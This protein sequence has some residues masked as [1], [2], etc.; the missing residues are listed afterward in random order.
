[1]AT[2]AI[3]VL[4]KHGVQAQT[5]PTANRVDRRDAAI[6]S[7]AGYMRRLAGTG[8]AFTVV[9]TAQEWPLL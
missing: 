7:I 2:S 8:P 1:M 3:D 4:K 9:P 6:Q 5:M